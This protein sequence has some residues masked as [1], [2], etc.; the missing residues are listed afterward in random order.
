[1]EMGFLIIGG[2]IIAGGFFV[3]GFK[4]GRKSGDK[5]VAD[6]ERRRQEAEALLGEVK[7]AAEK[8][9]GDLVRVGEKVKE[10]WESITE[11]PEL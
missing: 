4:L 9:R 5:I 10:R 8:G 7:D 1:M 11:R 2:I 3:A 6:I